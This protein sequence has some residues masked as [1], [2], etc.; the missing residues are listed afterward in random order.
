MGGEVVPLVEE[1]PAQLIVQ[2]QL[3]LMALLVILVAQAVRLIL[4][5]SHRVFQKLLEAEQR[6]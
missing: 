4:L 2:A 5:G 1:L 3:L 6:R